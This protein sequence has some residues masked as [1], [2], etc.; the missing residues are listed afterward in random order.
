VS[1]KQLPLF[2][3]TS[4][5]PATVK[6]S[7][8]LNVLQ[9]LDRGKVEPLASKI[10]RIVEP[11]CVRVE[12]AG[13]FRRLRPIINDLD[14]VI[15]PKPE[16]GSWVQILKALRSEFDAVTEKQG[17]KLATL[18]L[19]FSKKHSDFE[20]LGHVQID[21][22]RATSATWG[23]LLLVRTGSKE[24]NVYLCNLALA[25]GMRLLYSQGL[26][27]KDGHVLAGRTEEE[28][29]Q[30]LGMP[31]VIPQDREIKEPAT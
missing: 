29:F 1:V 19:R 20:E 15:Q 31:F 5:A 25:K 26:V 11:F 21:L 10:I 2:P 6:T 9:G 30:A 4:N 7:D 17:D 12:V 8:A 22:Y 14:I 23:I 18:Y 24:H 3:E 28:V 16:P 27:D 13:S